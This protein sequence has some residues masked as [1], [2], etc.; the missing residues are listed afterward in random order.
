MQVKI[1]GK[2]S[3]QIKPITDDMIEITELD[4]NQIGKTKCFDITNNCV[5]DYDNSIDL[6]LQELSIKLNLLYENLKSTDY[7]TLKISEAQL[8][9]QLTQ[10]DTELKE[11]YEKY[12]NKLIEREE[13][14]VE[15]RKVEKELDELKSIIT[16]TE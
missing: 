16:T 4:L 9:F 15:I 7:I 6:K 1:L 8:K 5:I 14:R 3:Y 11:L 10:D 12:K 13:W 2:F